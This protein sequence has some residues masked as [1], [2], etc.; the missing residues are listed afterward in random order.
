[1]RILLLPVFALAELI[2]RPI[3][4]AIYPMAYRFRGWAR[5]GGSKAA[6]ALWL[7]LDDSIVKDSLA[8][9]GKPLEYCCYGKTSAWVEK[10][11]DGAFKEFA[12]AFYWGAWRNN[13]INF[14]SETEVLVGSR[15][16]TS[17]PRPA[18]ASFYEVRLFSGGY[19]LPYLEWW[20]WAGFRVQCGWI[21][22]GR[23][24]VQARTYP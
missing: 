24:Q 19:C 15:I 17:Q 21:S 6:Y 2:K 3:F 12:R 1:M 20:P 13:G 22:C 10:L 16:G 18:G 4:W 5:R 9:C 14:M 8:R 23:F 11:K 7:A